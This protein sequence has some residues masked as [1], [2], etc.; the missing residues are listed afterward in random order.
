MNGANYF[1]V[2]MLHTL[3]AI[4]LLEGFVT[5]SVEIL[6]I[7]QLLPFFGGSVAITSI[8]IGVF[9]LFLA[10]GY[11]RGGSFKQ[12][13]YHKLSQNFILSLFWIGIG[14]SYGF[15]GIFFEILVLRLSLPYMLCLMFYLLIVLAPIVY[16]LGQ[17]IPLT[18]NLFNQQQRISRISGRA[19]FLSTLGSF[20]G[21]MVTSLI[22]F[23]YA[24]VA[25]TIVFNCLLLLALV[26]RLRPY[27]GITW[28]TFLFLAFALFLIKLINVDIEKNLFK[29]TNN[30]ANYQVHEVEEKTRILEINLSN[31]SMLT[32]RKEGFAYIEFMRD[33]LFNQ[34]QM[35]HKKILV[36]GAGGFSFTAA[37]T[38]DNEVTYVD[39]DPAIKAIAETY[40]LQHP[41]NGRFIGQDARLYLNQV[42]EQYDVIISDVYSHQSSI[43][44]SLLT[45]DY[46]Q[47]LADHLKPSGFV[48]V[49][50]IANPF[51]ED[52]YSRR[53]RNTIEKIF[54]FCSITPLHWGK[55]SNIMFVCRLQIRDNK[56][57]TDDLSSST[58]DFFNSRRH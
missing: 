33:L 5:I 7:R 20:L 31:S 54:P 15:M 36:I 55:A 24:G 2:P 45:T 10:L 48:V 26:F 23:Q 1:E 8:I 21:A 30:Y 19:L 47:Q 49:N 43:P 22:L 50:V 13:F 39:I 35:R 25:W 52:A 46:F 51:F 42:S 57:Y 29:L 16:W 27:S 32:A 40:F 17:T 11:W 53:T 58:L 4:L 38:Q 37:G 3:F 41:I 28:K 18:T 12:D 14:L 9:L 6:T 34:L 44:A 56:F